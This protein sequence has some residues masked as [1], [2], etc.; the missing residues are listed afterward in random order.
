MITKIS[1]IGI[2]VICSFKEII[3]NTKL[4]NQENIEFE[5]LKPHIMKC[6][7]FKFKIQEMLKGGH[8]LTL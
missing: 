7:A 4:S 1:R 5:R 8:H 3:P 6:C 2:L